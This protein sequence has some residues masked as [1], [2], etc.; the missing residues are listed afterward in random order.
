MSAHLEEA[1]NWIM[2]GENI[3]AFRN[4]FSVIF[5]QVNGLSGE[6]EIAVLKKVH[7]KCTTADETLRDTQVRGERSYGWEEK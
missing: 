2:E 1:M 5:N 7:A 4:D 6:E 3:K